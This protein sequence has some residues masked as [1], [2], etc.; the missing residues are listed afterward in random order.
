MKRILFCAA[1]VALA[2]ACTEDEL[3]SSQV[4]SPVQKGLYFDVSL[5]EGPTTKGEL[6][7]DENGTYPFFW[8]AE[9]DRIDV[10][11]INVEAGSGNTGDKGV[12]SQA[13]G[14]WTLA[15][16][17]ASYKATRSEG[18]GYF[19]AADDA[20]M[21]ELKDYKST[22]AANTTATVLATYGDVKIASATS[23][24]DSKGVVAGE[25]ANLVLETQTS[26]ATQ[27]V[28]RAN[29]VSAPMWS[30][31]SA[32]KVKP[33]SSLGE[34]ADLRLIRPFPVLRFTTANTEKYTKYFGKLH[35]VELTTKKLDQD[36]K[37]YVAGSPIAYE[38]N[39]EYTVV[40]TTTGW[41][42][43]W[44]GSSSNT[45]TVRLSDGTWTDND[46]VYM[47][48][49]PVDRKGKEEV[50]RVVYTFDNITFT[51]DGAVEGAKDFEIL[52][53]SNNWTSVDA[54]GNPNAVTSLPALDINKYDYLVVGSASDATLILNRG[55]I[56][57][58]FTE[59]KTQVAWN[60][61]NVA[62][63]DFKTVIVNCDLEDA[64]FANLNKFT[65]LQ[66]L[67]LNE[68]TSLPAGALQAFAKST[69]SAKELIMPKVTS[70]NDKFLGTESKM[71]NVAVLNTESYAYAESETVNKA[72]FN[73]LESYLTEVNIKAVKDM[74]PIF[75][76][77]EAALSFQN[78]S[79]LKT[80]TV[81]NEGLVLRANSFNNCGDLATVN[82]VV[83][84][85]EGYNALEGTVIQTINVSSTEFAA[86]I[87]K[88]A[89]LLANVLYNKAQV[90]PTVIGPSAFEGTAIQ[91]MDLSKA[92]SIG[93]AAFKNVAGL[94]GPAKGI[95]E[96]HVGGTTV[97]ESIFEGCIGLTIVQFDS[98]T[99]FGD[100]IFSGATSM[101]QIKF[102]K[103]FTVSTKSSEW[104]KD[105]FGLTNEAGLST[106]VVLFISANGQNMTYFDGTKLKLA[107]KNGNSTDYSEYT[108]KDIVKQ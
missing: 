47:T 64:D 8:Y 103:P 22:D 94:E 9:Q 70:I 37:K 84:P 96:L 106:Q 107:Y 91:Y 66:R 88:N 50:L 104:T 72:M 101:K 65:A 41:A 58:I 93:T 49:A 38:A 85:T 89:Y 44:T 87:F 20:N 95:A 56:G 69:Q 12:A 14:L 82:G 73:G 32:V 100:K 39:K 90:A 81:S 19:T 6:Y 62:I 71:G 40:G 35:S 53:T 13:S 63:G 83:N 74:T 10:Q 48:V 23:K 31:S 77:P 29:Y 42:E 98:A 4:N 34:R 36:G 97:P 3:G 68:E 86:S 26:N 1:V 18:K 60:E 76:K 78:Y 57:D 27:T 59:D 21:L 11:A 17:P 33:Y 61:G 55:K 105:M 79:I 46:A 51:L 28:D 2:T 25:L 45:V 15:E 24:T 7:K 54:N 5:A 102:A 52:K 43:S 99:S 80:V 92:T 75:G 16:D 108:F 30:V 67:E